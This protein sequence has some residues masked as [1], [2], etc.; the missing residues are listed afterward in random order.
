MPRTYNVVYGIWGEPAVEIPAAKGVEIWRARRFVMAL[1]AAEEKK[2]LDAAHPELAEFF[3]RAALDLR[4]AEVGGL[5][6][7]WTKRWTGLDGSDRFVG[8]IEPGT[9]YKDAGKI[10][11]PD[12]A[13]RVVKKL[14]PIHNESTVEYTPPRRPLPTALRMRDRRPVGPSLTEAERIADRMAR[15][16]ADAVKEG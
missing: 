11:V 10:P 6:F 15:A 7:G 14:A 5:I 12:P 9:D 13:T 2:N 8:I 4:D 3:G 16:S 1:F